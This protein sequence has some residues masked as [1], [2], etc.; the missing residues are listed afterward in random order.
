MLIK[1]ALSLKMQRFRKSNIVDEKQKRQ[2]L[3]RNLRFLIRNNKSLENVDGSI[4]SSPIDPQRPTFSQPQ[5][6]PFI[7]DDIF[8]CLHLWG[9]NSL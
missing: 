6:I 7:S 4:G 2:D 3:I 9:T 1:S 5:G 8:F